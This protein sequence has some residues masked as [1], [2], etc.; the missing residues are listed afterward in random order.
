M[1]DIAL[2]ELR[3]HK[4]R[5]FLTSLGIVI[6][7]SAIVSLGSISAGMSILI[8]STLSQIG[9]DKIMVT[10]SSGGGGGFGM[11]QAEPFD[12]DI[13]TEIQQMY[14]VDDALP[15]IRSAYLGA[16]PVIGADE[17]QREFMA[18]T[19]VT[20]KEGGWYDDS[21]TDSVVM[22]K[23]LAESL[24][25]SVGDS[26]KFGHYD[27]TVVG[28][29]EGGEMRGANLMAIMPYKLA[30]EVLN[31]EGETTLVIVKPSDITLT[32]T[33]KQEVR[34][35]YDDMTAMTSEDLLKRAQSIIG[36][37]SVVTLGIG[38]I[39]SLVAAL[40]IIIT[41]ITSISERR[42]QIGIMKAV[43][44]RGRDIM[45]QIFQESIAI[46]IISGI[47]GLAIGYFA[48]N[49]MNSSLF[50]GMNLAVVTP[51][52]AAGAFAYG[53]ILSIFS[54][55]YPARKASMIDPIEAIRS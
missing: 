7:I 28:V 24:K 16:I 52:L 37:I 47:F 30:Q 4:M 29:I 39:A 19:D 35:E 38:F 32:D 2:A 17:K 36:S 22:G 45:V 50:A 42:R 41:M 46:S 15:I 27:L 51:Q 1:I 40:G 31:I 13:V 48:V 12:E 10:K 44:A 26:I 23:D 49:G 18:F 5:T 20:F 8:E 43:G 25:L 3:R 33:I 54:A 11:P 6:A 14:G 53:V 9:A 55:I 21:D 34:D